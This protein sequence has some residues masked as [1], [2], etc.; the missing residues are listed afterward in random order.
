MKVDLVREERDRKI[1][2]DIFQEL[3]LEGCNYSLAA[4]CTSRMFKAPAMEPVTR[5]FEKIGIEL[6]TREET[7]KAIR[8]PIA[9]DDELRRFVREK[10]LPDILISP[11]QVADLQP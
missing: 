7:E 8:M 5:F 6:F 3:P 10:A 9:V 2:R 11:E 4:T 1:L